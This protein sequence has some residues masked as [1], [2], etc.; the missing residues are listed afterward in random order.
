MKIFYKIL[1]LN[2]FAICFLGVLQAVT[3]YFIGNDFFNY[4]FLLINLF[5][6]LNSKN[7][8]I[9][10]GAQ[11]AF[12]PF[13]LEIVIK[14]IVVTGVYLLIKN[15][16]QVKIRYSTIGL[17]IFF[18]FLVY[19]EH[20]QVAA[21]FPGL[22]A[23][24][25]IM[26]YTSRIRAS[27]DSLTTLLFAYFVATVVYSFLYITIAPVNV[28]KPV[29]AIPVD[30]IQILFGVLLTSITEKVYLQNSEA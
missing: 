16:K 14:T 7:K 3:Y 19:F 1:P 30:I 20:N 17:T 21:L 6:L 13:A 10:L 28:I 8:K 15:M 2:N 29:F 5:I 24:S 22:I 4:Y 23:F 25:A 12:A 26:Y 11:V 9:A 27:L 18:V